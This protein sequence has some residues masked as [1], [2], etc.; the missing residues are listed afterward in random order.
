MELVF[1]FF[2]ILF[3]AIFGIGGLWVAGR[4]TNPGTAKKDPAKAE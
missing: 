2:V 4:P 3:G 1:T